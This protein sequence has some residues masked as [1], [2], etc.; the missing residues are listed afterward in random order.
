MSRAILWL[1]SVYQKWISPF[2]RPHCRFEPSCSHYG[3]EAIRRHGLL[4]GMGL[5]TLRLLKCQPFH[6]GGSDPVP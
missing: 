1:I 6:A 4:R 2:L 3:H 5:T